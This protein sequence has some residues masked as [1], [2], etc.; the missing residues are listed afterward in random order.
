MRVRAKKSILM[1]CALPVAI[2]VAGFAMPAVEANCAPAQ[3]FGSLQRLDPHQYT[4]IDFDDTTGDTS[5][6]IG[7]FWQ[8]DAPSQNEGDYDVTNWLTGYLGYSYFWYLGTANLGDFRVRG[9]PEDSLTVFVEDTLTEKFILW[10]VAFDGMNQFDFDFSFNG[11]PYFFDAADSP[12]PRIN[13]HRCVG[14]TA[15]VDYTVPDPTPGVVAAGPPGSPG[16]ITETRLYSQASADPPDLDLP[17]GWTLGQS[18]GPTGG[19]STVGI[20]CSDEDLWLATALVVEGEEPYFVVRPTRMNCDCR[21]YPFA[22]FEPRRASLTFLSPGS[23]SF[24]FS[25]RYELD[26]SSNGIDP[27]SEDVTVSFGTYEE[28]LAAGGF[29]CTIHDCVYESTGPGI[30]LARITDDLLTVRAEGLDLSEN[31]NPLN[32]SVH[33]GDDGGGVDVRLRGTL[34]LDPRPTVLTLDDDPMLPAEA[35]EPRRKQGR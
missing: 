1:G 32:V 8:T 7:R 22:L 34:G 16:N 33:I 11:P 4:Y 25:A 35:R 26:E 23:D 24:S 6:F 19:S 5:H 28:T 17:G 27:E 15:W 10:T 3:T 14:P 21:S 2:V 13:S 20:E 12:R 18:L 9:C 31:A 29:D 30:V